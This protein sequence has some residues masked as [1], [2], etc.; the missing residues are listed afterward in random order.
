MIDGGERGR[1]VRSD[2]HRRLCGPLLAWHPIF[3][4]TNT[5]LGARGARPEELPLLCYS[6]VPNVLCA[7]ESSRDQQGT[8]WSSF[9]GVGIGHNELGGLA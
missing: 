4:H 6:G 7:P 8:L 1:T 9:V 5:M 3:G 2:R